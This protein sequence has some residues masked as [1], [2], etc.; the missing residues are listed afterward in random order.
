ML[1]SRLPG[2]CC[3]TP[4]NTSATLASCCISQSQ[5]LE[6]GSTQDNA[7]CEGDDEREEMMRGTERTWRKAL[8]RA[9]D[10]AYF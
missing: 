8:S 9:R 3:F 7:Q 5:Q 4:K 2:F 10:G 6:K 1:V